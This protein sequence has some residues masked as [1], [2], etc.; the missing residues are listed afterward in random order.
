MLQPGPDGLE[1][2]LCPTCRHQDASP[3]RELQ[4]YRFLRCRGC[5]LAYMS[6]RPRPERLRA[7]YTEE[8]FA[9]RDPSCGYP[10]YRADRDSLREKAERLLRVVERHGP[11]GRLLDIGCALGFTLEVARER[12]WEAAGVEASPAAA[13]DAARRLGPAVP[14]APDLEQARFPDASFD[15]VT[16]WDVIEHLPDPRQSLLEVA[17]LLR[18]GGVCSVVTP[19]V[20]SLAAKVLGARW[21]EMQKMPE[22]IYFFDRRSLATLLRAT[23]FEPLEWGTVGKRMSLEETATRL[24]PSAPRLWGALRGLARALGQQGRVAY[25]DPRWKMA[26]TARRVAR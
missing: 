8:Y 21:E 17:R 20:G 24:L 7:L 11:R 16:L 26:V 3:F 10:S 22:H 4:G 23:G 25:F 6:P 15:A 9:S 12:G 5:G 13:E 1:A 18:P 14:I 19:D 2:A